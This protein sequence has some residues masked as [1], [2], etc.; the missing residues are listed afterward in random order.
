MS[1][2]HLFVPLIQADRETGIARQHL[3]LQAASFKPSNARPTPGRLRR[4][5]AWALA[6]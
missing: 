2:S 1:L 3:A 4:R 6:H 5:L